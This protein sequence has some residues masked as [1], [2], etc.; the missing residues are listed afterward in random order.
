M[1]MGKP[2]KMRPCTA[3]LHVSRLVWSL[4]SGARSWKFCVADEKSRRPSVRHRHEVPDEEK[5]SVHGASVGAT[6]KIRQTLNRHQKR[7][8]GKPQHRDMGIAPELHK[9]L[10][11]KTFWAEVEPQV[12]RRSSGQV[13]GS[14]EILASRQ[15]TTRSWLRIPHCFCL[16]VVDYPYVML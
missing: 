14:M 15:P 12:E 3:K 16:C 13:I 6:G 1:H 10:P 11:R 4:E 5:F 7:I 8:L 9:R 2:R